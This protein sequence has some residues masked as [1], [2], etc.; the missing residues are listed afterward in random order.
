MGAPPRLLQGIEVD[1]LAGLLNPGIFRPRA[2]A[3][4]PQI[5]IN[6]VNSGSN[7]VLV[8]ALAP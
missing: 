4:V 7:P 8:I 2:V 6:V 5:G 3:V 1:A